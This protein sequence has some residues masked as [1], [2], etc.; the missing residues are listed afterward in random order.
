MICNMICNIQVL[1]GRA[2]QSA[3]ACKQHAKLAR[4]D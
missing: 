4:P 2:F 3:A 1:I